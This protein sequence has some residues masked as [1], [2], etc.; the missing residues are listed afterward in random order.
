MAWVAGVFN[1]FLGLPFTPP[2]IEILDGTELDPREL[3]LR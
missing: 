3:G 2:E 1:N